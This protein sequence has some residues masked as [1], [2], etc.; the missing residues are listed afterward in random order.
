MKDLEIPRRLPEILRDLEPH[1]KMYRQRRNEILRELR[2]LTGVPEV[3]R[4]L[5]PNETYKIVC[6]PVQTG[7]KLSQGADGL[8]SAVFRKNGKI[9]QHAKLEVVGP[10]LIKCATAIGSQILLIS[11]AVQLNR[12]E[13]GIDGILEG[14]HGD[15]MA[16]IAAGKRQYELAVRATSRRTQLELATNAIQSLTEGVEKALRALPAQIEKMPD[17]EFGTLD[18]WP[19]LTKSRTELAIETFKSVQE[20]FWACVV[21]IQTL[22][23]C[24]A[25]LGE[26]LLAACLSDY[27]EKLGNSET[28]R[29]LIRKA[30]LV[31]V[32]NG[33]AAEVPLRDFEECH[34]VLAT[35]LAECHQLA[36]RRFGSIEVEVKPGELT[37]D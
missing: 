28:L 22:A 24:F 26:P 12:V 31:P 27:V 11:I 4:T 37:H 17:P 6:A 36:G 33:R 15:R 2:F 8:Y 32:E 30:R 9:V 21:G 19:I 35:Q 10:S 29:T 18:N 20:S 5:N 23:E 7:A 25:V 1:A 16:E 34:P 13:K 3:L 14:L